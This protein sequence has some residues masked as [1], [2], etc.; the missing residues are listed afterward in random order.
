MT[1]NEEYTQPM[2]LDVGTSRIVVA[3]SN[4]KKYRYESQL[5]AFLTL[6][7]S[8]LAENLLVREGVFHE[9][10]DNDIVVAGNDAHKFAEVFHA[11]PRRPM[12][13][14]I[15]NPQEPHSIPVCRCIITRLLAKT[16]AD[17]QKIDFCAHAL[18]VR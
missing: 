8:R 7:Y 6:P 3:R 1:K 11:E 16:N 18:R 10:R 15:L 4:D 14:G 9:V 13:N 17:G 2:G 12:A 5:N